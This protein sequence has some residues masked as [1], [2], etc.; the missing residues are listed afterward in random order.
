MIICKL[1][2]SI[3][4]RFCYH[5]FSLSGLNIIND[6]GPERVSWPCS[7]CGKMFFAHCGLSIAPDHGKIINYN[8]K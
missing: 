1:K 6:D 2:I 7:K 3:Y 8:I 5:E 4:K